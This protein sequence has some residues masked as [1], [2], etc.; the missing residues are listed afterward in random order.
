MPNT[1]PVLDSAAVLGSQIE[2]A[3]AEA[4]VAV[5]FLAAITKGQSGAELTEMGELAQAGAV[6]FS[7]D[8][9]PVPP[10]G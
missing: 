2:A 4:E 6:G 7:D 9:R 1:D 5:G 3:Q 10:R 8:G